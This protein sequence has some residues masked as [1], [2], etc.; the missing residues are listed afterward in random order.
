MQRG[1]GDLEQ[2]STNRQQIAA[3]KGQ[4]A[5]AADAGGLRLRVL[6]IVLENA[7]MRRYDHPGQ[8]TD[9]QEGLP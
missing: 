7:R 1:T 5:I 3:R 9:R 8:M 4:G 2:R 6:P